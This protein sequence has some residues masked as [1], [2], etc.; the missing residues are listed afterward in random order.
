MNLR[1]LEILENI[2]NEKEISATD[3]AE[4]FNVSKRM[5]RYDIDEIN[6][7]LKENNFK[8]IDKKPN[9]PLKFIISE[10][11][12]IRLNKLIKEF[13]ENKYIFSNEER[14]NI[15]IY[16]ILSSNKE[17]SYSDLMD[18][19]RVSKTTISSD[20]RKVK[21]YLKNFNLK[22][23]K[24]SNKGFILEGSEASIRRAMSSL[25]KDNN[26]YNIINTLEKLY[27]NENNIK[28][29]DK[30]NISS[31]N[32][33]YIK[34]LVHE[35]EEE[36]GVFSEEDFM[37][38][39]ITIFVIISRGSFCEEF[40]TFEDKDFNKKYKREYNFAYSLIRKIEDKFNIKV[41]EHDINMITSI[42]LAGS[43]NDKN[44]FASQ[45]YFEACSIAGKIIDYFKLKLKENFKMDNVLYEN[46]VI[47]IKSLIFRLRYNIQSQNPILETIKS[48]Y[49]EDF[50]ACK[51]A[52][53]FIE[54]KYNTPISDDEIGYIVIYIR[55]AFQNLVEEEK[56][57]KNIIIV[58][59]GG[60]ATGR[61]I[62]SKIRRN[63]EVNIVA[64]TSIHNLNKYIKKEKIDFIITSLDLERVFN[65]EVIKVNPIITKEDM[66]LL[67]N[68][69]LIKENNELDSIEEILKIVE[70]NCVI[71]NRENLI[72]KLNNFIKGME[73]KE[74]YLKNFLNKDFIQ[75]NLEADNWIDAIRK[76]A[77]PLIKHKI[78]NKNYIED[79]IEN[80]KN[81]G[82][83]IVVDD[84]VAIPHSKPKENVNN[85]G[86]TITT[87]KKGISLGE[88]KNVRIFITL[89]ANHNKNH[90]E[91]IKEI[92]SLFDKEENLYRIISAKSKDEIL[93]FI[94]RL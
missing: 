14:L 70:E 43:K 57:V 42:I 60:F 9:S 19:L 15:L 49:N 78:I 69:L 59:E 8:Q 75:I 13:N 72:Y 35:I 84:L 44:A 12:K 21:E 77:Y 90:I 27:N 86:I 85:Y 40:N 33:S 76:S 54:E 36:L 38:L 47:H 25:L 82:P 48:N 37:N 55:A 20:I 88:H 34:Q 63:F 91:I 24:I 16:E 17:C 10:E 30:F 51:K 29:I 41:K 61:L 6:F 28:N 62:E 11:E 53:E 45:D 7:F 80:V 67:K 1:C 5:I 64:L 26:K 83:Y 66:N 68:K 71:I 3:L 32:L 58:C 93:T 74:G 56:E 39:V 46:F 81:F 2:I 50:I 73:I 31:E 22:I 87:F 23:V 79:I 89:A 4:R 18:K 92:M 52:C 94:N 65:I